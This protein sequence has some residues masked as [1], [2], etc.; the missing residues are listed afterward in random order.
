MDGALL[1]E[2][3]TEGIPVGIEVGALLIEG[4]D[5]GNVVGVDDGFAELEEG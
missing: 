2:G 4:A 3:L 5:V 1:N